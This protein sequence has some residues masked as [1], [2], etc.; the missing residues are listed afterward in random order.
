M[1][2][3]RGPEGHVAAACVAAGRVLESEE[4]ALPL[5]TAPLYASAPSPEDAANATTAAAVSGPRTFAV[6][7]G[8]GGIKT[9]LLDAAGTQ[10]GPARRTP[11]RYPFSP[12][13][14]ENIIAADAAALRAEGCDFERLTVGMPGMLRHGVVVYTPHYIRR[15]GP[16][17]RLDPEMEAAWNGL[18]IRAALA[19]RFSRPTLVLND[20][21]VAAA[22]TVTGRGLEVVLTFGTGLGNAI[23]DNGVLAPHLEFSHAPLRWG[24]TYDDVIGEIERI[25]LGD[26]AWSRQVA[27]AIESLY[28]VIRWDTLYLGGGNAARITES[29]RERLSGSVVFIPNAA[30]MSGGVRA[31]D[32]V[33]ASER[34]RAE[35]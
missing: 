27:R 31:W 32:L 35:Q 12:A 29:V 23:V 5:G 6:D 7:C 22:A 10:I 20:A 34:A 21:E 26:A 2:E 18:D 28:P 11:V 3:G 33:A 16:H 8:G 30:G 24:L 15:A 9:A 1:P 25:R 4:P 14:L 19:A 17:T 13:A